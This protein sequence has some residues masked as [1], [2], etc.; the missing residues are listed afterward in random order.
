MS[1]PP[2]P[3][4]DEKKKVD[5]GWNDPPMLNYSSANPPPKSRIMNK[6]VAFPM[7]GASNSPASTTTNAPPLSSLQGPPK[8]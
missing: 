1:E 2:K 4:Q 7:S 3:T 6:R 8:S 5:P